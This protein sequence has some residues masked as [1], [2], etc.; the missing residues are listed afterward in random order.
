MSEVNQPSAFLNDLAAVLLE[1]YPELATMEPMPESTTKML[2]EI[3]DK[4]RQNAKDLH[5]AS[6]AD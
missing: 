2:R 4:V 1:H 5:G 6:G 3:E